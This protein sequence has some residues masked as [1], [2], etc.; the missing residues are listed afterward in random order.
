MTCPIC[1]L[2]KEYI[3]RENGA[4]PEGGEW[5]I[6]RPILSILQ[7]AEE[8]EKAEADAIKAYWEKKS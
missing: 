5:L 3:E 1:K 6:L 8:R 2:V 4:Y 7:K